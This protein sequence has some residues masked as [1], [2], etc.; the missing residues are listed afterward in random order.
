MSDDAT[1][2]KV[3]LTDG[4]G[5][6]PPKRGTVDRAEWLAD[7]L[8]NGGDYGKEAAA[9]LVEQA[10]ALADVAMMLKMCAW[11]LRRGTAHELC[12]RALDLLKRHNLLG[13]PLRSETLDEAGRSAADLYDRRTG[14]A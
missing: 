2:A 7:K 5:L 8:H 3:R 13:S 12:E 9:L 6:A 1:P 10:K 11:A 4:L 14:K